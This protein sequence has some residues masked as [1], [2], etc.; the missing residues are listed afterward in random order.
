M[1]EPVSRLGLWSRAR[2]QIGRVWHPQTDPRL[3]LVQGQ[4]AGWLGSGSACSRCSGRHGRTGV[5]DGDVHDGHPR[6]RAVLGRRRR[7]HLPR[8]PVRPLSVVYRSRPRREAA[9]RFDGYG[10]T[11][12]GSS[13][14]AELTGPRPYS[15]N[16]RAS[17]QIGKESKTD[18]S[19]VR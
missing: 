9:A 13:K 5:P 7:R 11:T 14:P 17:A 6:H 1:S 15:T 4:G 12:W 16:T 19:K 8:G 3:R 10:V 2:V 18:R